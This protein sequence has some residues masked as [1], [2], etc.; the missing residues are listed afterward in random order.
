[1]YSRLQVKNLRRHR[2]YKIG[3]GLMQVSWIDL[4]GNAKAARARILNV[5][6]DGMSLLLPEAAMPVRIRF[7]SDRYN[8]MGMGDVRYCKSVGPNFV[9]GVQ[10]LEDLHWSPPEDELSE[11]ISL[12]GADAAR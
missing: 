9:V 3:T 4:R 5:S 8:V 2:R 6:E 7:R 10:F 1:M 12:C 11:P